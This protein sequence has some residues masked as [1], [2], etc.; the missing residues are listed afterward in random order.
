[1]HKSRHNLNIPKPKTMK[2]ILLLAISFTKFLF[3]RHKSKKSTAY[4]ITSKQKGASSWTEV[5]LV[6]LATGRIVRSQQVN[7]ASKEQV[8]EF[9]LPQK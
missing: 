4:A 5:R 2:R 6:N 9:R 7:V 8:E 1:M 3:S